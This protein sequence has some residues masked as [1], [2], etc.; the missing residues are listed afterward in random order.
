MSAELMELVLFGR[1]PN[2]HLPWHCS[3]HHEKYSNR[4]GVEKDPIVLKY[5]A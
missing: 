4:A 5:K 1:S 2:Y 3:P